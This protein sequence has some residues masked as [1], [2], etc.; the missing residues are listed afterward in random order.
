MSTGIHHITAIAGDP[1]PNLEFYTKVL[2]LRLVKKTVNF[3]DPG[4]YH[5]YYADATGSPGSVL[6]FFPHP[7]APRGRHGSGQ[8]VEISFA[9]PKSALSFWVGRLHTFGI[10]YQGPEE[11]FGERLIRFDDPDG[12]KLEL[13]AFDG[14]ETAGTPWEAE[15][16]ARA[17]AIR[18]FHSVTLWV[19]DVEPTAALLRDVLGFV[20]HGE[21][22]GIVR[23][24]ARGEGVGRFVD[25]RGS[26][27][28]WDGA[29]GAGVNH[30]VAFR[31]AD[32]AEELRLRKA[33]IAR[34][35]RVTPLI[36]RKYFH[37]IYFREPG[38]ILFEIATDQPGF[39]VDEPLDALG[40]ALQLPPQHEARR[41]EIET[42]LPVL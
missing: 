37:S 40:L 29:P 23:L 13:V 1:K 15:G 34:G 21:E 18:G 39:A 38:G 16:I 28:F 17:E 41:P 42:S 26:R 33:L 2:G 27:G 4:T 10:P 31:A 5:L 11:R 14:V 3:D 12:L 9:I 35:F 25:I 20:R 32:D 30:H 22:G 19:D 6:T 7:G 24:R 36:D 8:A